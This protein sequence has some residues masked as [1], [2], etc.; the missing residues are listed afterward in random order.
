MHYDLGHERAGEAF[1]DSFPFLTG[2][3]VFNFQ[4]PLASTPTTSNSLPFSVFDPNLKLPYTLNWHVSLQKA[5]GQAQTIEAGYIGSTGRRLLT[6]QTLFDANQSFPFIRLTTNEGQSNYQ[7]LYAQFDRR[8][9][10]HLSVVASYTWSKSLDNMTLDSASNATMASARL[11]NDRGPSDFDVRHLLSGFV[12]FEIP[13][14]VSNGLGNQLLRNWMVSSIFST[15]TSQPVNVVYGFPTSF[16]FAYLRPNLLN[17][18]PLYLLD[19]SVAGGRRINPA[20]F[21]VPTG[22]QQGNLGRNSLRGY[23]LSQIDLG[24][25][26]KFNFTESFGL[27]FQ[28]DAFNL[29]NH[30]NF[31]DPLGTDMSLGSKFDPAGALRPNL[32]FGQSAS[33]N[34][35]SVLSGGGFGSFY[36]MGSARTLR[37]SAKLMF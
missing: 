31:E 13:A 4:F 1:T 15:R 34:G 23:P 11:A 8:L 22:L 19:P 14:I 12:T 7:A 29:L 36:G 37:F 27:Q 5:L 2:S 33:L 16:G 20:A 3:S 30:P 21:E 6:T 18:E 17:G 28:V 10:R 24:L 26:R 35:M 32:T 9:S 25:R